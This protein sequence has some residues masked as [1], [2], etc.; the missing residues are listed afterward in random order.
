MGKAIRNTFFTVLVI[1]STAAAVG[2]DR[3]QTRNNDPIVISE[4]VLTSPV[5]TEESLSLPLTL[6]LTRPYVKLGQ[7]QSILV[8]TVPFARLKVVVINPDGRVN[9]TQTVQAAA[10][11]LGEYVSRF[12]LNDFHDLGVFQVVVEAN[13]DTQVSR[14]KANFVLQSWTDPIEPQDAGYIYPLVP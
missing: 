12:K 6:R 1:A 5:T 8:K 4:R 9:S 7:I 13:L 11:E 14:V 3:Q 10:D 2:W